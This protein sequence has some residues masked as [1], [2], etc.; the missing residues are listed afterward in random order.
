M[1]K[2]LSSLVV[3]IA[4]MGYSARQRIRFY[5]KLAVLMK[6]GKQL[7]VSVENLRKRA[8]RKG[9]TD[10]EAVALGEILRELRSG[11]NF[12]A[13]MGH[14]ASVNERM[15]LDSGERSGDL[16]SALE[17][18]AEIL[19]ASGQMKS[20]V[21]G[22]LVSP[23]LLFLMLIGVLVLLARIVMPKL[24]AVLEPSEWDAAARKLYEFTQLVNTPWMFAGLLVLIAIFAGIVLSLS[25]WSGRGRAK[26]DMIP[27]WSMFRLLVGS[28]WVMSLASLIKSGE[29]VLNAL[30]KMQRISRNNKWLYDRLNKTIFFYNTG[31]N[32]GEALEATKTGFPDREIVDDLVIYADMEGFDEILYSIGKEWADTGLEKIKQQAAILN[33]G[34]ILMVGVILGWF[35]Y[36][37][38]SI[39]MSMGSHFSGM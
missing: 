17:L 11:K 27:P 37:V 31:L 12:A 19:E 30:H 4:R 15:I 36:A 3:K 10:V 8:A 34:A 35:T 7:Q 1:N 26:A 14:Y 5:R 16:P 22:A 9:E 23:A 28:G 38:V 33:T 24:T 25:R 21:L 32:L 20:K 39:Q 2:R 29:T 13:A 6:N 18:A